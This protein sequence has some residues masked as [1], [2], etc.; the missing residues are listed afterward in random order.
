MRTE[1]LLAQSQ[2]LAGELQ[3]RQ[4]EL[5]NTNQELQEKA[6]LLAHQNVEVER[7]NQEVEQA[8]KALE[9]KAE[10]LALTSKYKSEF[11]ANMSHE[12][13]TPLNSLLI[14]SDQLSKNSDGN[15]T[16]EA[17]RVRQDHPLLGHRSAHADQ[18]HP[19][20]LQDRVRHRRGGRRASCASPICTP[21]SSGRSGTWPS[22]RTSS[23]RSGWTRT[24]RATHADRRQAA[25]AGAQEPPRER[26]QVHATRAGVPHDLAGGPRRLRRQR[27]PAQRERRAR[28]RG[29]RH[30]DR[31]SRRQAAHHLRGVPAGRRQHE[32]QVRRHRPRSRHQPGDRSPARRARSSW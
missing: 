11:L 21:T 1:G 13:R 17:D 9:E 16:G 25:A 27:A 2:S 14:L 6:R 22:R 26:V 15:L 8:R 10:Q 18:R 5:Q 19:R 31:H 23:S 28:L 29:L 30:R 7:K 4:E 20:S 3:S 24:S 32:P 12:L